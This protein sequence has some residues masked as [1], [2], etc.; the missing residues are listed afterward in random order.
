MS[1]KAAGQRRS[2][3]N[4]TVVGAVVKVSCLLFLVATL[5]EAVPRKAC[6]PSACA[7]EITA[8]RAAC[9]SGSRRRQRS[10]RKRCKPKVTRA[11]RSDRQTC[12]LQGGGGTGGE[13]KAYTS[14][15]A[16]RSILPGRERNFTCAGASGAAQPCDYD[17]DTRFRV[18]TPWR[19]H[20]GE[21]CV[22]DTCRSATAF[23][24]YDNLALPGIV[25]PGQSPITA[26]VTVTVQ[27]LSSYFQRPP[28][29]IGLRGQWG[30]HAATILQL[31][32]STP[33]QARVTSVAGGVLTAV[34]R[35]DFL[36][37]DTRPV[38]PPTGNWDFLTLSAD[39]TSVSLAPPRPPLL[40]ECGS[41]PNTLECQPRIFDLQ[42]VNFPGDR[43]PVTEVLSERISLDKLCD[44]AIFVSAEGTFR[45]LDGSQCSVAIHARAKI[46][47]ASSEECAANEVCTTTDPASTTVL[48]TTFA[49]WAGQSCVMP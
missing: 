33:P 39:G 27:T 25:A 11:C 35:G 4:T 21:C 20:D 38:P 18:T 5:A 16:A 48:G 41:A 6:K 36:S 45:K 15:C 32:C 8:C 34:D 19:T 40:P 22:V 37:Y 17:F 13:C 14:E 44:D 12:G 49:G 30:Q 43:N 42:A 28:T 7:A 1:A 2:R 26:P 47:C 31:S 10:C 24:I 9:S 46:P 23:G 3:G 29:S